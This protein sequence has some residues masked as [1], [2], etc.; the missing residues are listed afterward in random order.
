[1][2]VTEA[3]TEIDRSEEQFL[4]AQIPICV[5]DEGNPNVTSANDGL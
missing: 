1:M 3:G 2:I 5:S 4:N